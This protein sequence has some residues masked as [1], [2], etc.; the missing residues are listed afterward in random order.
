M[1]R[2]APAILAML[3]LAASVQ[4]DDRPAEPRPPAPPGGEMMKAAYLGVVTAP[5]DA[6]LGKQL[7]LPQGVGLVVTRVAEDGPSAEVLKRHDVLHKLGEQILVNPP[8][9]AVLIRMHKPGETVALRIIRGGEAKEVEVRLAEHEVPRDLPAWPVVPWTPG[10]DWRGDD[11]LRWEP[12]VPLPPGMDADELIRRL[13]ER[14]ERYRQEMPRSWRPGVE[15]HPEGFRDAPRERDR[16]RP[17]E[18]SPEGDR[19]DRD[20]PEE[21]VMRTTAHSAAV[22]AGERLIVSVNDGEHQIHLRARGGEGTLVVRDSGGEVVFD[23]PVKLTDDGLAPESIRDLPPDLR[24]KLA[25]MLRLP[26]GVRV[27]VE[28]RVT[29]GDR[30]D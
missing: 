29:R 18:S 22:G 6:A 8:Q 28:R 4:A 14:I 1:K 30:A 13:R 23:G 27:H 26:G 3:L 21:T 12:H 17:R 9:L 16:D 15:I 19:P 5:V 7:R 2:T 24:D 20:H 10:R 25:R 11:D